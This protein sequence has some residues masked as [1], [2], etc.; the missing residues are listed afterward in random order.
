MHDRSSIV[1]KYAEAETKLFMTLAEAEALSTE[2]AMRIR[3]RISP[4]MS[5]NQLIVA[6]IANG[7]L[8]V[9]KIVSETLGSPFETIRIRRSGSRL[10]RKI[11]RYGWVVRFVEALL[12]NRLLKKMWQRINSKM[13]TLEIETDC[14]SST[15]SISLFAPFKGKHV[16]LVDDCILSGQTIHL[17][18][19]AL[20]EAGSKDVLPAVLT[21][22]NIEKDKNK[23]KQFDPIVYLNTRIQHYPWSQNNKEYE[24]FLSWLNERGIKPWL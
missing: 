4:N 15:E 18:K 3:C 2:L 20:L 24:S 21:L 10:K 13:K 16:I 22:K 11:G 7:G 6:G 8:M 12:Q 1:K 23:S 14:N 5:D 9:A 17:A 19:K